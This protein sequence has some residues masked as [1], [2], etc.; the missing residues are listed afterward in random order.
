MELTSKSTEEVSSKLHKIA[1]QE[2]SSKLHQ[3]AIDGGIDFEVDGGGIVETSQNCHAG[4]VVET[5]PNCH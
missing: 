5:S 4:I 2:L 1:M 3:I